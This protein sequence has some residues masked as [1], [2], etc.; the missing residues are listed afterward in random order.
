VKSLLQIQLPAFCKSGVLKQQTLIKRALVCIFMCDW[1]KTGLILL[2]LSEV[3][4]ANTTASLCKSGVLK[5]Q[6]LIKR[7]LVCIF[8][9]D[10]YK[11]G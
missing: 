11:T 7:A 5:Q 6:T 1:Y 10:W 8:M 3:P 9:C 2:I 4:F